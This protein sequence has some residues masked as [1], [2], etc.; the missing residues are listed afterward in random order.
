M[1]L[2]IGTY[3]RGFEAEGLYTAEAGADGTGFRVLAVAREI[4]NPSWQ[5]THPS[6]PLSYSVSEIGDEGA[7]GISAFS[8]G[9]DG[10]LDQVCS[11]SSMGE[12]PCH[13]ALAGD[14]LFA[15]NYSGGNLATWSLDAAGQPAD[16]DNL[17]QHNGSSV[18]PMRQKGPHVHSATLHAPSDSMF[19]C[20]LGVDRIFRYRIA[21]GSLDVASRQTI[22]LRPGAGPRMMCVEPNGRYAFVINELDNTI[23]SFDLE[24]GP[25]AVELATVGTVPA[26]YVDASYCAHIAVSGDGRFLYASNRGHD[27]IAVFALGDNGNLV[28][29]QHVA[30]GGEHPRFFALTPDERFLW[31]ANRDSDNLVVFQRDRASG[32][33]TPTGT[34]IDMPAPACVTWLR[35]P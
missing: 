13:L 20:D 3:T 1:R 21:G 25:R 12:D 30:S 14:R 32:R 11:V 15:S 18:D 29:V 7:G 22:Q 35:G 6:L 10:R 31:A 26:D 24:A 9:G 4:D 27:S 16:L 5:I 2:L 23:V 33:L 28:P 8:I 34:V 19:V 17:I